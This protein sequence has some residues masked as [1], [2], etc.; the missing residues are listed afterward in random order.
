MAITGMPRTPARRTVTMARTFLW[1]ACLSARGRGITAGDAAIMAG[2]GGPTVAGD[3]A[4][5]A[6]MAMA[7]RDTGIAPVGPTGA[8]RLAATQVAGSTAA[9]EAAS[10]ATAAAAFTVEAAT[11]AGIAKP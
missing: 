11:E 9:L 7:V 1:A 10:V 5:G 8:A 2:P 6:D 3:T 4:I